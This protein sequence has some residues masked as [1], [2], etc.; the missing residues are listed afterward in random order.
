MEEAI[1]PVEWSVLGVYALAIV[2]GLFYA[3][4]KPLVTPTQVL[5]IAYSTRISIVVFALIKLHKST[6]PIWEKQKNE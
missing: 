6:F 4:A 2:G 5:I 1:K 3:F